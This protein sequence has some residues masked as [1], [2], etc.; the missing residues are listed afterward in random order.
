LK[1]ILSLVDYWLYG[2]FRTATL[3][4]FKDFHKKILHPNN[5]V[6]V[7]A[8]D[9]KKQAKEWIEKL[10]PNRKRQVLKKQTFIEEPITQTIK[11]LPR[12]NIQIPMVVAS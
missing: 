7:V 1:T 6:L 11:A 4:D 3:E 5:A 12:P 9:L 10:W 8:G 2:T